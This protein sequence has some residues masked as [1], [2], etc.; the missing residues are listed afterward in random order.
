MCPN[1]ISSF[2]LMRQLGTV[3]EAG[4]GR[5]DAP[6]KRGTLMDAWLRYCAAAQENTMVPL[7]RGKVE[8]PPLP[9]ID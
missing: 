6:E 8:L 9:Y 5:G 3:M 1:V 2:Q 4:K 7:K